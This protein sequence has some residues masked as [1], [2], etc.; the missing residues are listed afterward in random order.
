MARLLADQ[1]QQDH[2]KLGAFEQ[3]TASAAPAPATAA[4]HPFP[5]PLSEGVGKAAAEAATMA[6]AHRVKTA[7]VAVLTV[8]FV[9]S[10]HSSLQF[11]FQSNHSR[12]V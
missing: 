7:M 5:E 1:R 11:Q 2:A 3:A 6:A 9:K 10:K 12:Y 4:A 8:P